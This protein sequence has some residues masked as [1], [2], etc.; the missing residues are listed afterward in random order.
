MKKIFSL[1]LAT[2]LSASAFALAACDSGP[3][4]DEGGT[5]IEYPKLEQSEYAGT[6]IEFMHFWQD[7]DAAINEMA[8]YFEEGTGIKVKVTLSP[9]SSHLTSLNTKMQTNTMPDLYTMWPGATMPGY[10]DSGW[11]KDLSDYDGEWMDRMSAEAEKSCMTYDKLYIAPVNM[12]FMGIAYNKAI[13]E[14]N[15]V[16][17]PKN[18][19]EF[20]SLM[21]T[22]LDDSNLTYPMIWGSDCPANMIYLMALSSVYQEEPDF[23]AKVTAGEIS[24]NNEAMTDLYEKLFIDWA[25]KGYYNAE[26]CATLDRMS[27]AAAQFVLGKAAMMRLGGWDLAIIDQL[28]EESGGTLEYGMFPIPGADNDGTVLAAAGEAVAVNA[29]LSAEREGA[30]LEFL[31]FFLSPAVNGEICGIINSLSPY[32]GV[33]VQAKDCITELNGYMDDSA[34][35][36]NAWPLDVQNKM[37]EC[38]NIVNEDGGRDA[39]M[40]VLTEH[41][42]Y[43]A[44]LWK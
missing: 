1:L 3:S 13:F 24:F 33:T 36:W 21:D 7:A 12:A 34:R 31:D 35:G 17:P 20:E 16:Q 25:E 28:V 32:T 22:L 9:V 39:K 5:E 26:T 44:S 38:L 6:E 41:L 18:M 29:K 43:L 37:G 11:V 19:A 23:D 30:A 8:D 14:R 2:V 10:V 40:R 27:K 15:N 4:K 42:E